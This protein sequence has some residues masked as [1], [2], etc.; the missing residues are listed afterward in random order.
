MSRQEKIT[1]YVQ[2]LFKL[3]DKTPTCA[4]VKEKIRFLRTFWIHRPGLLSSV[5]VRGCIAGNACLL[6]SQVT[7]LRISW[8]AMLDIIVDPEDVIADQINWR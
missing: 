7:G 2:A 3:T 6:R 4:H 8:E 5:T 1:E